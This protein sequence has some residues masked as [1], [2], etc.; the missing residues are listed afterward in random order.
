MNAL[1]DIRLSVKLI[2]GFILVAVIAAIVG[3][4]GIVNLRTLEQA[5]T[6]LYERMTIPISQ[7]A[8]MATKFQRVRVNLRD[9]ILAED[10]QERQENIETIKTLT[11]EIDEMATEFEKTIISEEMRTEFNTFRAT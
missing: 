11:A 8:D 10:N 1:N 3:I 5:D 6:R 2:A 9:V 4:V 7:L